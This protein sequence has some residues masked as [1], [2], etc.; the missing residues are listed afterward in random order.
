MKTLLLSLLLALSLHAEQIKLKASDCPELLASLNALDGSERVVDQGKE[1][2]AKVVRLSYDFAGKT[3]FAISR[4]IAALKA[5]VQVLDDTRTM[6]IKQ[7]A[8]GAME[9]KSD[10]KD[11]QAAFLKLWSDALAQPVMLD[12]QRLKEEDLKLD[13]NPIPGTVLAGLTPILDLKK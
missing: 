11:K 4:N 9:I 5:T 6:L 12:L 1:A 13:A 8:G 7:A 10:E 2:P 3:R